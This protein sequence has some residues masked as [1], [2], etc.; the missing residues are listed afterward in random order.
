[1][2]SVRVRITLNRGGLLG[3]IDVHD[4]HPHLHVI[5]GSVNQPWCLGVCCMRSVCLFCVYTPKSCS[6]MVE[7]KAFK[8]E[9]LK[10]WLIASVQALYHWPSSVAAHIKRTSPL[11]VLSLSS[12]PNGHW[13]L[14]WLTCCFCLQLVLINVYWSGGRQENKWSWGTK[15][16]GNYCVSSHI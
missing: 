2:L 4:V 10:V 3:S 13:C 8:I 7:Y 1:M 9:R 6:F 16:E 15:K 14:M 5:F 11:S 12:A